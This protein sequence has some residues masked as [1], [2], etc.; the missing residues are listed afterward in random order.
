MPNPFQL[1]QARPWFDLLF[2][3]SRA[4]LISLCRKAKSVTRQLAEMQYEQDRSNAHIAKESWK[5][6]RQREP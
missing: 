3:P 2:P 4:Q 1:V 6:Q 5:T